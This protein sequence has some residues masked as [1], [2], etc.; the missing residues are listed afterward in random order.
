MPPPVRDALFALAS[1]RLARNGILYVSYNVLPGCRVRQAAW[2]VLHHLY[3]NP[4][5]P[6]APASSAGCAI[7]DAIIAMWFFADAPSPLTRRDIVEGMI[8]YTAHELA[9]GTYLS[10]ITRHM[11]GL[12]HG[13]PNCRLWRRILSEGAHR[14]AAGVDL[15]RHALDAVEGP[16]FRLAA[17]E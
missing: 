6:F 3:G 10:H 7:T 12:Y 8:G 9:R 5:V 13:R 1:G 17:A 14:K 16:D 15:L 2:D 11:L 4:I